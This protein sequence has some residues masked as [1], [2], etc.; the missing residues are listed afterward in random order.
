MLKKRA[1]DAEGELEDA[2]NAKGNLIRGCF[3]DL[4]PLIN[5]EMRISAILQRAMLAVALLH[6]A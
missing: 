4:I 6:Y 5:K 3:K 2:V 1:V